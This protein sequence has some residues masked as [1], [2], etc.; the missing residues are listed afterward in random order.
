ML[1]SIW[2]PC[3]MAQSYSSR[4]SR[5]S[6]YVLMYRVH[7][8]RYLLMYRLWYKQKQVSFAPK[9]GGIGAETR[10]DRVGKGSN[11]A[12]V[13]ILGQGEGGISGDV[14]CFILFP[15]PSQSHR[16]GIIWSW[17][18]NSAG[19]NCP[20]STA[21]SRVKGMNSPLFQGGCQHTSQDACSLQ[22][23]YLSGGEELKQIWAVIQCALAVKSMQ[24]LL[25]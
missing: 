7:I 14:A 17:S 19:P 21:Y 5:T 22:W 12:K 8:C 25:I 4:A 16:H 23:Q 20:I 15:F 2:S 1:H 9:S 6:R 3:F 11:G 10:W 18:S 13:G 24:V